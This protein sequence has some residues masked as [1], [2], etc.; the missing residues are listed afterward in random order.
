[1]LFQLSYNPVEA[2]LRLPVTNQAAACFVA[3]HALPWSTC[4]TPSS[5]VVNL[6]DRG[7]DRTRT[8]RLLDATETLY[9]MS[10]I[11]LLRARTASGPSH[12][13][14]SQPLAATCIGGLLTGYDT[15]RLRPL[16]ARTTRC[17]SRDRTCDLLL[18]REPLCQLSYGA[19]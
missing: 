13:E 9:Q 5:Q 3:C 17:P 12:R 14:L 19:K 16:I 1:M 6:D 8:C 18:N 7:D 15:S 4:G 10:Y 11:P 2:A